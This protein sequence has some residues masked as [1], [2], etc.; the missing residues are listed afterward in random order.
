MDNFSFSI[1]PNENFVDLTMYQY[2]W[3]QCEPLHSYGAGCSES[4]SVPSGPF[5][6]RDPPFRRT[7]AGGSGNTFSPPARI[8]HLPQGQINT[9]WA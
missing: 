8:S 9:Y 2:G 4:L 6:Q 5:R 7:G 3:E 1:F